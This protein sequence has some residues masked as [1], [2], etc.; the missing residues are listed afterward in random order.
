[1][2][3]DIQKFNEKGYLFTSQKWGKRHFETLSPS[4]IFQCPFFR[5]LV[6]RY[7]KSKNIS[8]IT[9]SATP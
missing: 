8:T 9:F 7:V 4:E 5:L 2:L 6:M 1:M 3:G